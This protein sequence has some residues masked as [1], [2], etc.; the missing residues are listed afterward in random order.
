MFPAMFCYPPGDFY[1]VDVD[2]SIIMY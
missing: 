2:I 1:I